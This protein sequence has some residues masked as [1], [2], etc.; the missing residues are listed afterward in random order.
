M[1]LFEAAS[2][3]EA[4]AI[5]LADPLVQNDCVSYQLFEWRIVVE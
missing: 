2:M 5:V 3:D 1:M 4:Q